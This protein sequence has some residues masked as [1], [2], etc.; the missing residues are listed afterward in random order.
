MRAYPSDLQAT[1]GK[2]I[3]H[4]FLDEPKPALGDPENVVGPEEHWLKGGD[5]VPGERVGRADPGSIVGSGVLDVGVGSFLPHVAMTPARAPCDG[6][7]WVC[8]REPSW[9][10]SDPRRHASGVTTPKDPQGLLQHIE[11]IT[12]E[13]MRGARSVRGSGL[14]PSADGEAE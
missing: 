6:S 11:P 7:V 12:D 14:L 13:A 9:L 3:T 4:G 1:L 8:E 10:I 5:R 2:A